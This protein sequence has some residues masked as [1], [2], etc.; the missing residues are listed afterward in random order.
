MKSMPLFNFEYKSNDEDKQLVSDSVV[1]E[2]QNNTA[3]LDKILREVNKENLDMLLEADPRLKDHKYTRSNKETISQNSKEKEGKRVDKN[4]II[5]ERSTGS[6]SINKITER[7][8]G[9]EFGSD[10]LQI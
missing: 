4:Q 6:V 1:K 10:K 3:Y 7:D 8:S 2:D 5:T 9:S